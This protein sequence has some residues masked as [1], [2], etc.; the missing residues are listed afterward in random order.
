MGP[1]GEPVTA[2]AD[3]LTGD[4]GRVVGC[5]EGDQSRGVLRRTEPQFAAGEGREGLPG[6]QGL[7]V[8]LRNG[9]VSVMP[10]AATGITALT[11]TPARASSIDQVRTM[12]TMAA[13]AA[14]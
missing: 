11:V 6:R 7:D 12:P 14:A 8:G 5:E 1:Q 10:V 13:F 2:D 3:G 9:T 4:A